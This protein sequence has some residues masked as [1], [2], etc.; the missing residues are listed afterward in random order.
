M[1]H[2]PSLLYN[3]FRGDFG[4]WVIFRWD[5]SLRVDAG[6]VKTLGDVGTGKCIL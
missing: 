4:F 5:F 6:T 3:W 1:N 2:T